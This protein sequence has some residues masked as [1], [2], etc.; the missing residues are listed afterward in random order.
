M[1]SLDIETSDVVGKIS[2]ETIT[3]NNTT[4]PE[5]LYSSLI[6]LFK[7][8]V[9]Y[10]SPYDKILEHFL[11][12][13][14]EFLNST[15]ANITMISDVPEQMHCIV[16]DRT[17][18]TK[19]SHTTFIHHGAGFHSRSITTG[20]AIVSNNLEQDTRIVCSQDK[21][22]EHPRFD[23]FCSLPLYDESSDTIIGQIAFAGSKD[24]YTRLHIE[25]IWSICPVI[26]SIAVKRDG[27]NNIYVQNQVGE[28]KDIF[29][30][31]M[32]HELRTPLNGI[33]GMCELLQNTNPLTK[34][35][36]MY[37]DTLIDCTAQLTKLMNDLLDFSKMTNGRFVL[38]EEAADIRDAIDT[39]VSLNIQSAKTPISVKVE[40][41]IPHSL[42]VDNSR[43]IQVLNNFISNAIKFTDKGKITINV[44]GS[45]NAQMST[46]F[47]DKWN[48][49]ISVTDTGI[50]IEKREQAK[51]FDVFHQA[52]KNHNEREGTGLG[53]SIVKEIAKL[54]RGEVSVKSKGLGHGS[55]FTFH[56]VLDAEVKIN[57]LYKS[58]KSI[59]KGAKILVVDDRLE[60]RM[61]LTDMLFEWK[62]A[63]TVVGSAQEAL[64]YLEVMEFDC[65]LIDICMPSM[66]GIELAQE[67][68][69][70]DDPIPLIALSSIDHVENGKDLFKHFLF[71]PL[72]KEPIFLALL[73]CLRMGDRS[74]PVDMKGGRKRG[75]QTIRRKKKERKGLKGKGSVIR[76]S[77]LDSDDSVEE[78]RRKKAKK[79]LKILGAEDNNVNAVTLKE[80]LEY[81]GVPKKNITI[82]KNGEECVKKAERNKYDIILMDVKMPVMDGITATK[83]IKQKVI[84]P[85]PIYAVSAAV[86]DTDKAKCQ[87]AGFDGFIPKPIKMGKLYSTLNLYVEDPVDTK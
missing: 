55:T 54:M 23:R 84:N 39:S 51:I 71:K 78:S 65:A 11:L 28:A 52:G 83:I 8:F 68:C 12:D 36:K 7:I 26:S 64:Q 81:Y 10:N 32:S 69:G 17:R 76:S 29:L 62:C 38:V 15:V 60:M 48:I 31:S 85:P 18:S 49:Y 46:K 5:S 37:I 59:F 25:K 61:Q 80:F 57:S 16:I 4:P 19:F 21:P 66:S 33:A 63:P 24:D 87:S 9:D 79:D 40:D 14:T 58:N 45:K 3:K 70:T 47:V 73:D 20:M 74:G 44:T 41:G 30:G 22:A 13:T 42:V 53:L 77:V 75:V 82:V 2:R 86:Q 34:K 1:D 35:Q 43:L 67:M 50:G 27:A 72:K 6:G 56:A